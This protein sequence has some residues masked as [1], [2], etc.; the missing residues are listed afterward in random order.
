MED[1]EAA[2]NSK[3]TQDAG[4]P[5]A[6]LPPALLG[7]GWHQRWE[8]SVLGKAEPPLNLMLHT[9]DWYSFLALESTKRGF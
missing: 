4:C 1:G 5:S 8:L 6:E 9:R 7:Q 3:G 2:G